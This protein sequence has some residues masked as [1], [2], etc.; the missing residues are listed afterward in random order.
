LEEE[1]DRKGMVKETRCWVAS[2]PPDVSLSFQV[3]IE[4]QPAV[5]PSRTG[6]WKGIPT[7][8]LPIGSPSISSTML[9][10]SP[11]FMHVVGGGGG[12]REPDTLLMQNEVQTIVRREKSENRFKPCIHHGH[13]TM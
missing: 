8:S 10:L 5:E 9:P 13:K 1:V 12:K 3:R 7:I 2:I 4:L 6:S 11:S